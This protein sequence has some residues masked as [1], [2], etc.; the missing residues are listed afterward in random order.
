M[1]RRRTTR[2]QF[3]KV[4]AVGTAGLWLGCGRPAVNGGD[5]GTPDGGEPDAGFDGGV[6][7]AGLPDAGLPPDE[8][9]A[10]AP[11]ADFPLGV[12][13]GDVE[14]ARGIVS[15]RYLGA[16]VLRLRVWRMTG[17]VY[18]LRVADEVV[19]PAAGGF[20]H[21][22]VA[23]LEA[24]ARY[25]YAFFEEAAG[26]PVRRS[27]IGRF[28]AAFGAGVRE[29]LVFGATSC[30]DQGHTP[31]PLLRAGERGDLDLFLLLGDTS[32]NDGATTLDE[33]RA[34][35]AQNLSKPE[36]KALRASTS[37][38]ATWDDHEVVNDFNPELIN[39]TK[40]A[41][42][43]AAMFELTPLRRHPIAP[44]RLWKSVKWGDTAEFFVL[45]CRSERKPS[46]LGPTGE[47]VYISRAQMDWFKA[48][49]QASTAVFK[50][51]LNSVPITDFGF[52][53]FNPDNWVVYSKQR[54]EI[55]GWIDSLG[56]TGILWVSGDH[57]FASMGKVSATGR[58]ANAYEVLAGPGAQD[59]NILWRLL[60]P[61]RWDY[62]SGVNNYIAVHLDPA[63]SE[64]R[65]VFHDAQD[66]RVFD[67]L[68]RL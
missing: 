24:G 37:V 53:G 16:E 14:A 39:A 10:V 54:D 64:A 59:A 63:T 34:K 17:D 13:S 45:D 52:S 56:L 65:V 3:L 33:Y 57:H 55:L 21:L 58:G 6:E 18:A 1:A 30:I 2:R 36:L 61:P 38:L 48:A 43:T 41:D 46:T 51:V 35:W 66:A 49:L 12:T 11:S 47:H 8:P 42:A 27:P 19:T 50:I 4:T 7:D 23:G 28:R 9:E 20:V 32:Y 40:M 67:R 31:T 29:R 15:T 5:A 44:D 60:G 26:Q 62:A 25:R 22:D 68:Y